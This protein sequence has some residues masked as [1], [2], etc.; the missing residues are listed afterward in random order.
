MRQ[1]TSVIIKLIIGPKYV[2]VMFPG[3]RFMI[4]PVNGAK[5]KPKNCIRPKSSEYVSTTRKNIYKIHKFK[6]SQ[7]KNKRNQY[8]LIYVF[9]PE[10]NFPQGTLKFFYSTMIVL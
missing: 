9:K 8:L 6:N 5:K 3:F 7:T 10:E 1:S 4:K 2:F